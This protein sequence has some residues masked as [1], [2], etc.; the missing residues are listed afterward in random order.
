[1]FI[2]KERELVLVFLI[3]P[4]DLHTSKDIVSRP[5]QEARGIQTACSF[6]PAVSFLQ[7]PPC[8]PEGT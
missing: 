7:F 8:V 1:M 3:M 4:Q 6:L 5:L 2:S